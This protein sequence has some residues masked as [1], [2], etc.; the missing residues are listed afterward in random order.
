MK[1]GTGTVLCGVRDHVC[2]YLVGLT[3]MASV[4]KVVLW[5]EMAAGALAITASFQPAEKRRGEEA[6]IGKYQLSFKEVTRKLPHVASASATC[7]F[8]FHLMG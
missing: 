1:F 8:C 2:F 7:G 4:T 6:A 3:C 5:P